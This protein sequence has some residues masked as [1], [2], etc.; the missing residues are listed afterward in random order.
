MIPQIYHYSRIIFFIVFVTISIYASTFYLGS[1]V[2]F[3]LYCIS[4]IIMVFYLTDKKS[5]YFEIFL[6]CYIFL[7]FWFKYIFSLIFYD[8]YIFDSINIKA[9]KIDQVLLI[10]IVISIVCIIASYVSK[11]LINNL[12]NKPSN[13]LKKS[14]F[15]KFYLNNRKLILFFFII[16]VLVFGLINVKYGFYQRGFISLV[17]FPIFYQNILK[18]LMMF[19][20][21]TLSCFFIYVEINN[22]KKINFFTI[23][24]SFI[25]IF[26]SYSSMLSRSFIINC[27]SLIVPIYQKSL[28][29]KKKID[30]YFYL[31]FLIILSL[32]ILS[33]FSVNQIR[34]IK[35][36]NIK[37]EWKLINNYKHNNLN[38]DTKNRENSINNEKKSKII[39][40]FNFQ[41]KSYDNKKTITSYD[42]SSF[43]LVNRWI[44]IDS[45]I[46]VHFSGKN[47][48][49]LFFD[50]L[51]EK[52]ISG[53]ENTFYESTFGLSE[54]KINIGTNKNILKG[55]TLPGFIT[56]LYYTGNLFFVCI[57]LFF[58]ILIFNYFEMH[59]KKISLGN[60]IFACFLSNLIATRLVHFGYA[61]KDSYLF[62]LSIIF[63]V[64]LMYILSRF[65]NH[66]FNKK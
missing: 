14:F 31:F 41:I 8:S 47:N 42:V 34:L 62:I 12:N 48:F 29:F 44:G 59:V 46:L 22:L 30:N 36:D 9:N 13:E 24:V 23:L 49:N 4:Q 27:I 20:F 56:F 52:K 15:E 55:N 35:L 53:T 6:S 3:L 2:V 7:G 51:K 37:K 17:D 63:A 5:S 57:I 10:G 18:W 39:Q 11:K 65:N 40:N 16:F 28:S 21:T 54:H 38:K 1:T 60:S 64:L 58:I 26:I 25:E 45:L 43:I 32:T 61:P 50:A 66:F 33:I 19:G